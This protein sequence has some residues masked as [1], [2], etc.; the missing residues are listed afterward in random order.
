MYNLARNLTRDLKAKVIVTGSYLGKV[1]DKEFF[2]PAGDVQSVKIYSMSFSEFPGAL[3]KRELQEECYS[4]SASNEELKHLSVVY[5]KIGGC[6]SVIREYL[7]TCYTGECYDILEHIV[8]NFVSGSLRYFTAIEDVNVFTSVLSAV[9]D[10]ALREKQGREDLIIEIGK[11]I[12]KDKIKI[13]QKVILKVIAWLRQSGI[14]GYATELVNANPISI[15][16]SSRLYFQDTSV[17]GYFARLFG[18]A[19]EARNGFLVENYVYTVLRNRFYAGGKTS[20]VVFGIEPMFSVCTSNGGELDFVLCGEDGKKIG[21]EVKAG[22]N[23]ADTG[24]VMLEA[25]LIDQLFILK[26]N[27]ECGEDGSI[28]TFPLYFCRYH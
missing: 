26:G 16:M 2:I 18:F 9:V 12:E 22:K 24:R 15:A 1:L 8:N 14:I 11:L 23:K 4:K 13:P 28:I 27:T 21:I 5:L 10:L 6:P 7:E 19:R 17:A 25:G 20:H 3:G